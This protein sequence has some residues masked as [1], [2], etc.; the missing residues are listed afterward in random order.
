M[1]EGFGKVGTIMAKGLVAQFAPDIAK[2]VL[3][4]LLRKRQV[5]VKRA[6]E[7]VQANYNLWADLK[8]DERANIKKLTSK[9]GDISWMDFAWAVDAMK[10]EYPAVASLFLGWTKGK[11]WLTR[12]IEIIR[13]ELTEESQ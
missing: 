11:N 3:V 2:G 4:E 5:N 1:T 6:S 7:W 9:V 12:Q 8:P 10:G 13:K